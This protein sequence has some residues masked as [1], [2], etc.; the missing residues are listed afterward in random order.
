MINNKT[1]L[2]IPSQLP[3]FIRDDPS[4]QNFTLFLQAYYEWME[5]SNTANSLV[6]TATTEQGPTFA[7]K[8]ILNY[9]DIDN[10]TDQFLNYFYNDFLPYFPQEILADKQKVTKI[11][12]ELYKTKG[13]PASYQFLFR[14]LYNTDVDFFYTK[15]A[16]LRAS[17]GKWYVAKSLKLA[18]NN[19]N[20]LN[21][22]NLRLFGE[23]TKSIATV[24]N[25][26][27]SGTK[28][29]V[30]ISNI[31]RL[32]QSGEYVRVVDSN[33]QDVLFGGQTLRAK[34]VGQISQVKI[35]PNNRGNYYQPGDP[36]IVYGG[37]NAANGHGA[38]ATVG[39][40]TAGAIQRITVNSGGYG[41]ALI[42]SNT[43]TT[44]NITNAGGA[45][46]IPG[47]FSPSA[48]AVANV[49]LIPNDYISF[50]RF[51]TIGNSNYHFSNAVVSNANT[52]LA[53]AFTFLS[54]T[55]YPISSVIVQNGGGGISTT[56]TITASSLYETEGNASFGDLKNLGILA[57]IQIAAGG[58]GYQA[59]DVI[60]FIGGNGYGARA[61]VLTVNATGSITSVGYVYKNNEYPRHHPLGGM[62]YT[63]S[64][65]PTLTITSANTQ[66]SNASLYVPGILGD[67]ATFS[68]ITD[69]V[70]TITTINVIDPGEDY[71][72]TPNVSLKVQD[73]IV[74][75]VSI[76]NIVQN[77][78]IIY[79]GTS[80]ANSIYR[81]TVSSINQVYPFANTQ[82]SLYNLRVYN[83]NSLPNISLPIKVNT[84]SIVM[85]MSNQ[86]PSLNTSATRYDS[87]GVITYGDGSAKA[88][89]SFLNGLVISQGQYLDTSGQPSSFDVLQ[90]VDYNNYTY[91][92]TLEKE[93]E[94]YRT[95]LLNLLHPSGMKVLGRFAMKSNNSVNFNAVDVLDT[96]HT[97]AYYTGA[98]GSNVTMTASFTNPSNNIVKLD[99]LAG[100]N[101]ANFIFANSILSFVTSYGDKVY[102]EITSI[103][104]IANTVTLKDNVWLAFANVAN[105]TANSG[106][107]VINIQSLTNSYNIINNGIYSNT[108]Y[109]LKDIV[110]AGDTVLIANNTFK[111]VSSV[112]YINNKIT[113]TSNLSYNANS[114]LSVSR[115]LSAYDGNVIFYGPVGT[116]YFPQLITE[117]GD[118]MITE[119]GNFILLG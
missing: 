67:G 47:S 36:V 7:S 118:F 65:L 20:F 66:A 12:K 30:F 14:V 117:S 115:T 19:T 90:S 100:S 95:T 28:T 77:G 25:S 88:N 116:Q 105:V 76:N 109:P 48:N 55:T 27:L 81:A 42:T 101:I 78:D 85:S 89:A 68:A 39:T 94:K 97:L 32:F 2:L 107:N 46:A 52:S 106:S 33:N 98:A 4:Y 63:S 102:S 44:I 108:S 92:I 11:A 56:P 37:L 91:Q 15:D 31:E 59:N 93:I 75:N 34:V 10:T 84:K 61:N 99:N 50:K 54:F 8:N 119:D 72:A 9:S 57:P 83:Y 13:T 3:E 71:V 1:S 103:D 114:F 111:T 21:I 80:Y 112:D 16:V 86:Y 40:T 69:R 18:T 35:D 5:L 104:P 113:L 60:N 58:T 73:I 82:Q 29:E 110:R 43:E 38:S 49:S 26:V 96:G 17:A 22:N 6:T 23:I 51:T 64:A 45:I 79:Q 62:G 70:G 53:N 41:Y 87:T 24:E 74:S